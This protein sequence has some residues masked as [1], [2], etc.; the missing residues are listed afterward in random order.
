MSRGSDE[1]TTTS[2]AI[3]GMLAIRPWTT[4]ELATQ[5]DRS[6]G[7]LWPRARSH[8]FKEPK[9]LAALGFARASEENRGRRPRTVYTITSR[10][11]SSL[12]SWL[13]TPG[14]GPVLEFEG[15]LKVFFAEHGTKDDTLT[16]I[17][18]IRAWA[19]EQIDVHVDVARAY[20]AGIGPFPE[21][22]AVLS[23]TGRF[24]VDFAD[25]VAAW[26]DRAADVVEGWPDDLRDAKPDWS[27]LETT[28]RRRE[29][30]WPRPR[31]LSARRGSAGTDL[32]SSR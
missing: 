29:G 2:Y 19:D 25:M 26:A 21:R 32:G 28:A 6:L 3:L 24:L 23:V 4:Y 9:R 10:G 30:G 20:L 18:G 5:M 13:R 31:T 27:F 14:G 1:L 8:L 15:L 22:L 7:R 16:A 11:R 17:R 12:R